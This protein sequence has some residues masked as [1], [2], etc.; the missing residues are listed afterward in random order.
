[1]GV[2]ILAFVVNVVV[3][4]FITLVRAIVAIVVHIAAVAFVTVVR[5]DAALL[6]L[7]L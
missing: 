3:V 1:M 4:V 6:L 5:V 2:A 7:C